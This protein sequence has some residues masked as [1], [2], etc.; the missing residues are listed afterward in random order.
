MAPRKTTAKK[1]RTAK[2]TSAPKQSKPVFRTSTWVTIVV[3]VAIIGI[4]YI[5]N[6]NAE[7]AVEAEITPVVEAQYV[8][9]ATNIITSI[10]VRPIAAEPVKLERKENAWVL[11]Q[12]IETEADAGLA[13]AAASQIYALQ[14]IQEIDG[15]PSIYGFDQPSAIITIEFENGTTNILEVGDAAITGNGYYVRLDKNK[16]MLLSLSGIDALTILA[17]FPPYL[18]TPAPTSTPLPATETLV[19]TIEPTVTP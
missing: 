12:P 8:F 6:R 7:V 17:D 4:A 14:I 10:E 11:T 13:E 1:A 3:F 15:D 19:P 5:I 9:D 18:N 2:T 16:M